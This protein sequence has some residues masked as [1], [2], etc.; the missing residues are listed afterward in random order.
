MTFGGLPFQMLNVK[1]NLVVVAVVGEL[2]NK[3]EKKGV[4]LPCVL[5]PLEKADVISKLN[6]QSSNDKMPRGEKSIKCPATMS[7]LSL[8]FIPRV[9]S[10]AAAIGLCPFLEHSYIC[11]LLILWIDR[12]Q[13]YLNL[14]W[15]DW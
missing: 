10:A 2:V 1:E 3:E 5:H 7:L 4:A 13:G 12:T 11:Q 6:Q 8:F 9:M 14:L 15:K